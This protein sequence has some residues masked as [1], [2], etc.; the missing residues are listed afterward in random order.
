MAFGKGATGAGLQI[1]FERD[2]SL[3]VRELDDYIDPPG[4][5]IR[6]VTAAASIVRLE[7]GAQITGDAS[8]GPPGSVE[9]RST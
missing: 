1:P 8:V 2:R 7:P 9:L 4:P 6:R 5:T 3:L